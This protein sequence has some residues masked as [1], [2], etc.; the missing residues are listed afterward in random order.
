MAGR[1]G[2]LRFRRDA[3][4]WGDS[5]RLARPDQF[6]GSALYPLGDLRRLALDVRVGDGAS[7]KASAL[8][9]GVE[10]D[11]SGLKTKGLGDGHLIDGLELRGSPDL[12]AV[13]VKADGG[14]QRL[15][16][17]VGEKRELVLGDEA[18]VFGGAV[19]G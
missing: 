12:G 16:R 7:A 9:L 2:Q 17:G 8:H 14:V 19:E 6:D 4:A 11:L 18:L 5:S 15:H 13:A 1:R 3:H 10:R